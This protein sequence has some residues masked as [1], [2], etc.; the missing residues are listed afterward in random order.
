MFELQYF[1]VTSCGVSHLPF[2]IIKVVAG[3]ERHQ[4]RHKSSVTFS[5]S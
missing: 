3:A 1:E 2:E 4:F 5:A